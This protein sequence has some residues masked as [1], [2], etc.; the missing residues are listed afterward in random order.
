MVSPSHTHSLNQSHPLLVKTMTET[1]V[2]CARYPPGRGASPDATATAQNM[3]TASSNVNGL[4]YFMRYT[5]IRK[6]I[7]SFF[8]CFTPGS[9]TQ[10]KSG[11][12]KINLEFPAS[13]CKDIRGL[14][15]KAHFC[16]RSIKGVLLLL[17]SGC[18]LTKAHMDTNKLVVSWTLFKHRPLFTLDLNTPVL[19]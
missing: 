9:S 15:R 17:T 1:H 14:P 13:K 5:A 19:V 6:D 7:A 18:L 10:R 8:V 3:M 16:C 2:L 4:H 12:T 11:A